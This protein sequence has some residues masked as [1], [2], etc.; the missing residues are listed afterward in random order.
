V[1]RGIPMSGMYDITTIRINVEPEDADEVSP[2]SHMA[3]YYLDV[4][5]YGELDGPETNDLR[6]VGAQFIQVKT[7]IPV[8]VW[9][10]EPAGD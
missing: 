4:P 2:M 3:V 5:Q 8:T 10:P 7:T 1:I 9:Y 6:E